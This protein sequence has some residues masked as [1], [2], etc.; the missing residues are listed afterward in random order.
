MAEAFSR[1]R[2]RLDRSALHISIDMQR[3]F[4][5]QTEWFMPWLP[6]VLPQVTELARRH[7]DRTLFTRF[8]PPRAPEEMPGAWRRYYSHWQE[9]TRDRLDPS[10]LELVDPLRAFAPPARLLDKTVYSAFSN[11]RL[12]GALRR[13]GVE[14]LIVSGGETDVCVLATVMAAIDHGFQIVL[15]TDA[16]CSARDSTHDALLTL[17]RERFTHQVETTSTE[18][19][20]RK[21]D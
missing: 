12:A 19:V 11:P 5:E 14:T 15:P 2:F 10:L 17:Y 3:L 8:I 6:R 21:W 16:L 9:M 1:S 7:P 13:R 18:R 4:A 20:L